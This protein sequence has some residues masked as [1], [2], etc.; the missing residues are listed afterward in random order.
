MHTLNNVQAKTSFIQESREFGLVCFANKTKIV[1]C[2]TADSK[3]VK[4]EVNSTVILPPL[5]FPEQSS[6]NSLVVEMFKEVV[7][8][9]LTKS[10]NT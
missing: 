9:L 8:H 4:E 3:L 10:N 5:V 1:S 6:P 2:H 7:G